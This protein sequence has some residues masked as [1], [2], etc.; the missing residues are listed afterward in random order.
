MYDPG[1]LDRHLPTG[2][3]ENLS[4]SSEIIWRMGRVNTQR[5]NIRSNPGANSPLVAQFD[6]G[7]RLA[8]TGELV[9]VGNILGLGFQPM[10]EK[11]EVG[12]TDNI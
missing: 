1:F 12:Q 11:F 5:L 8:F 10:M 2:S 4:E 3:R 9:R 7:A 6:K